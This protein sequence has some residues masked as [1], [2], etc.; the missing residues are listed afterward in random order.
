MS[1]IGFKCSRDKRNGGV[2]ALYIARS[3]DIIGVTYDPSG[4]NYTTIEMR[5]NAFARFES[6]EGEVI[7]R[8]QISM[9][10][11][12][13]VVVHQIEFSLSRMGDT[14]RRVVE[15]L[16]SASLG[17]LIAVVETSVGERLLVGY[18]PKFGFERALKVVG[19]SATT[20]SCFDDDTLEYVVLRSDDTDKARTI[21]G[22]LLL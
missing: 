1:L 11:G 7:Y 13:K 3:S 8:E 14:T 9:A 21:I 17:G 18:S 10:T 6:R 4:D 2:R 12:M 5:E 19:G 20:G 16:C 15:E 22:E